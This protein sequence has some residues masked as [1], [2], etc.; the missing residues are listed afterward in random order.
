MRPL[1]IAY[2]FGRMRYAPTVDCCNLPLLMGGD[3]RSLQFAAPS[4]RTFS[5]LAICCSQRED[6][7]AA[8]NLPLPTGGRFRS[9]QFAAPSGRTVSQP[10]IC[11]SQREDGFAACNLP[12]PTGGRFRSL[13]FRKVSIIGGFA[14]ISAEKIGF[15]KRIFCFA[16]GFSG[17]NKSAGAGNGAA[18]DSV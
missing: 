13:H 5:Q 12:L 8:C 14:N 3:F 9:L 7:F 4:G 18:A 2:V 1:V 10:A 11:R 16:V 6:V 17:K 15:R